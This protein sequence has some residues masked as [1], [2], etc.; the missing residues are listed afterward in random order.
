[1]LLLLLL[2]LGPCQKPNRRP[3]P[4]GFCTIRQKPEPAEIR[5][6]TP[7]SLKIIFIHK[8]TNQ[9]LIKNI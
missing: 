5:P 3:E 1:M 7:D 9:Q 4:A 8:I 6:A 2:L